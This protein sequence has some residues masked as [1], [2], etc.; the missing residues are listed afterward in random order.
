[1]SI[2]LEDQLDVPGLTEDEEIKAILTPI[3]SSYKRL[4]AQRENVLGELAEINQRMKR[5]KAILVAADPDRFQKKPTQLQKTT[6]GVPE[7]RRVTEASA[8]EMLTLIA[9][10]GISPF[11]S[12]D[13]F[14][15]S[16]KSRSHVDNCIWNLRDSGDVRL[17]GHSKTGNKYELTEKGRARIDGKARD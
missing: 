1:M 12:R 14:P 13:L 7:S 8:L 9:E 16:T 2:K 10:L 11:Q 3:D 4:E 17:V 5:L 6:S 15:L